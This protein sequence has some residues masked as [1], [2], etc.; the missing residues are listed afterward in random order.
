MLTDSAAYINEVSSLYQDY[1][2]FINRFY[3]KEVTA[4][5]QGIELYDMLQKNLRLES[6]VRDLD[7]D[8]Q[9]LHQ[10]VSM[11]EDKAR[12]TKADQLNVIV[13]VLGVAAL[14][15]G[16]WGMN[17]VCDVFGSHGWILQLAAIVLF[18]ASA[19]FVCQWLFNRKK[20]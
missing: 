8:I 3:F 20:S 18:S 12:N 5:D 9:E 15:T 6:M 1:I 2:V 17:R 13:A 19:Y 14:V 4:Q 16:F 7:G 11:V 10:Y